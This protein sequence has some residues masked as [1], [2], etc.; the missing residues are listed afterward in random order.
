MDMA[1]ITANADI[2]TGP[3]TGFPEDVLVND[4]WCL[5]PIAFVAVKNEVEVS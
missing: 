1:D 4:K 5:D 2:D 3:L